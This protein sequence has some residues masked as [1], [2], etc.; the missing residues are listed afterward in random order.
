MTI[1]QDYMPCVL[2][3]DN[4]SY[5]DSTESILLSL[6]KLAGSQLGNGI[7]TRNEQGP[8][9]L[10]WSLDGDAHA[11]FGEVVFLKIL[12]PWDGDLDP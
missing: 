6:L 10:L 3:C 11:H 12:T 1:S 8:T 9:E 2:P 7:G 4:P 5:A